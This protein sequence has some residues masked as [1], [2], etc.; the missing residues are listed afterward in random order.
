[1]DFHLLRFVET[2]FRLP[3]ITYCIRQITLHSTPI[4]LRVLYYYNMGPLDSRHDHMGPSKDVDMGPRVG[5]EIISIIMV[6]VRSLYQTIA[7]LLT[8]ALIDSS[9]I[10]VSITSSSAIT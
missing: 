5:P 4:E 6:E 3:L 8:K 10:W 9:A 2:A 1:M 7:L